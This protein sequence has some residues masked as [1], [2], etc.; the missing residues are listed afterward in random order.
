M[1][2]RSEVMYTIEPKDTPEAHAKWYVFLA[3]ARNCPTTKLAMEM[4]DRGG[5]WADKPKE[6][7]WRG[8]LDS[9]HMAIMMEFEDV[10]WYDSYKEPESFRAL[11]DMIE[12]DYED[13]I[14]A[15]YVRKGEDDDDIESRY[16]GDGWEMVRVVSYFEVDNSNYEECDHEQDE[17]TRRSVSTTLD[18]KRQQELDD[19]IASGIMINKEKEVT[20]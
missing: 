13:D 18:S 17:V 20:T 16:I 3:E 7:W 9:Q 8:G 11:F 1:G 19:K 14:S 12:Q 10:K 2:Y 6:V 15:A 5:E 4:I